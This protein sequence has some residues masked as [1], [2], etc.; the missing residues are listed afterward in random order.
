MR[1]K[2]LEIGGWLVNH[3]DDSEHATRLIKECVALY[4]A[5][6]D[7]AGMANGL[8]HLGD[9]AWRV[10]DFDAARASYAE[11]LMLRRKLGDPV[12]IGMSLYSAGRLCVDYGH[13]QE[14][15]PLLAEGLT[16]LASVPDVRGMALSHN[17]LGRLA[18]FQ[19]DVSTAAEQ[20]RA[21]L[22]LNQQLG[23]QV[24]IA[25]VLQELAVVSAQLG[26]T[27]RA[28]HL[29]SAGDALRASI[30]VTL[31]AN[32]PLYLEAARTWLDEAVRSSSAW[33]EGQTVPIEKAIAY[34]LTKTA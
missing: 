27:A 7:K 34:A 16:I 4:R 1:A 15:A 30:G 21:A 17:A 26:Q 18:L 13:Y 8:D 3:G 10:G 22:C 9:I 12:D 23:Y 28:A 32:D 25:E 31:P 14:A 6:N 29:W 20:F 33:A 5:I 24:D 19:G 11:S 2:A